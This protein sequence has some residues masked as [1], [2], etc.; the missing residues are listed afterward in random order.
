MEFHWVYKL[1]LSVG[2]IPNKKWPT[3]KGLNDIFFSHNALPGR[4]HFVLLTFQVFCLCNAVS[5]FVFL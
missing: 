3:E 5:D 4:L 2:S 1:Y